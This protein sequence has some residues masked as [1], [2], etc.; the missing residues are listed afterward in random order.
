VQDRGNLTSCVDQRDLER[1]CCE[2][3]SLYDDSAREHQLS[4]ENNRGAQIGSVVGNVSLSFVDRG[5]ASVM[6]NSVV[7]LNTNGTSS[8]GGKPRTEAQ[9]VLHGALLS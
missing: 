1:G 6:A 4:G 5:G 3:C 2:G 7:D 9:S 8:Y